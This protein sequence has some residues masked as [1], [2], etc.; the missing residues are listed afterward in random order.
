MRY[1]RKFNESHNEYYHEIPKNSEFEWTMNKF[2]ISDRKILID[3]GYVHSSDA[4]SKKIFRDP[5][6]DSRGT[7]SIDI[8]KDDDEWYMVSIFSYISYEMKIY[9]C[10]QMEGVLKLLDDLKIK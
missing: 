3:R 4:F 5:K 7:I 9:R 10:D 1:L 2:D 8:S 6:K